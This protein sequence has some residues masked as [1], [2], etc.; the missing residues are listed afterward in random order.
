MN[1]G[2]QCHTLDYHN[3]LLKY[4]NT[5]TQQAKINNEDM[6]VHN[7]IH[8]TKF[9]CMARLIYGSFIFQLLLPENRQRQAENPNASKL[10]LI[11]II[12]FNISV[13]LLILLLILILI[14]VLDLAAIYR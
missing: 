10:L 5:T 3:S 7:R 14:L 2:I 4:N 12:Y 11:F 6:A 13:L 8:V 1:G 9:A